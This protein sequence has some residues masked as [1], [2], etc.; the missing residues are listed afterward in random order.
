MKR[1]GTLAAAALLL[2]LFD[3]AVLSAYNLFGIRPWLLLAAALA[4]T[5]ALNVQSGILVALIG[6]LV[7][8]AIYNSYLGLTAACYLVSVGAL[9]L[10][11]RRNHP[12]ALLLWALAAAAVLLPAPIEWLYSYLAGAQFRALQTV[13]TVVLPNAVL[14]GLCVLPLSKLFDWAKKGHR[15]RI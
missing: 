9:Y 8:D 7:I 6:G 2:L 5:I 1:Y 15:D 10:F 13:L 4:A 3:T 11:T 14:T 12:K